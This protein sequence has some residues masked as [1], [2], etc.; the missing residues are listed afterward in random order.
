MKNSLIYNKFNK[1]EAFI[2]ELNIIISTLIGMAFTIYCFLTPTN[3][4]ILL[5]F[6]L[7]GMMYNLRCSKKIFSKKNT[8][9]DLTHDEGQYLSSN[10]A[11]TCALLLLIILGIAFN[12]ILVGYLF[13]IKLAIIPLVAYILYNAKIVIFNI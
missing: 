12:P 13:M 9:S 11:I 8:K 1:L 6:L 10:S 2:L 3:H 5:V 4:R 7:F